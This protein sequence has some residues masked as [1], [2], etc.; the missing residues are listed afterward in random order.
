MVV[1][2][3]FSIHLGALFVLLNNLLLLNMFFSDLLHAVIN[4]KGV[5]EQELY[6]RDNKDL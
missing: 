3:T 4:K 1:S 5:T 2:L 6:Y